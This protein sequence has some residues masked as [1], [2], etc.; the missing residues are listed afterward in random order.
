MTIAGR[1]HSYQ[2]PWGQPVGMV[3]CSPALVQLGHDLHSRWPTTFLGCYGNRPIRGGIAT[4]THAF[5]AALDVSYG[6]QNFPWA[7]DQMAGYLVAWSEEWGLQAIHDYRAQRIWRA[8]RTPNV[9]DACSLWWK[10]QR[11]DSNGMGQ[12]WA[13]WFHL[14]VHPDRWYDDRSATERGVL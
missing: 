11:K 5:G 13:N 8:G 4:S 7:R 2:T 1:F 9:D 14:E 6:A 10:A 3:T 12:T